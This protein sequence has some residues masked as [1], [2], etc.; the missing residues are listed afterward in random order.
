MDNVLTVIFNVESEGFQAFTEIQGSLVKEL[1]FV[2]QMALVKRT[3]NHLTTLESYES[4]ALGNGKTF[5]GGLFGSLLGIIGGPV[6]MLLGGTTG[7][8]LGVT[9]AADDSVKVRSLL[10]CVADKM[11][12]GTVAIIALVREEDESPLDN[13]LSKFDAIIIRRNAIAVVEEVAEAER[14]A[15]EMQHQLRAQ[16]RAEKKAARTEAFQKKCDKLKAD[17]EAFKAK[18]KK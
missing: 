9:A 2:P 11:L 7:A 16:L 10:E 3:G 15:E 18:F 13:L 12:D 1:Y 4:P 5:G 6:G 8:L 17:F 14:L